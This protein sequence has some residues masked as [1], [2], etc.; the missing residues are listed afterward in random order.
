MVYKVIGLMS[1][2]SLDGLDL[3]FAHFNEQAGA[4]TFEI[5]ETACYDYPPAW[6]EQLSSATGLSAR[7][8]C[9]LH[10]AYGH[11]LGEMSNRFIEEKKIQLEAD[12]IASHGHTVFHEPALGMTAQLGDGAAIASETG[13]AVVSDLRA[14]DVA[15]GGEGAPI[16]PVGEKLLFPEHNL[17]LNLGGIANVSFHRNGHVIAFDVCPANRVLNELAVLLGKPFDENGTLAS[18]GVLNKQLLEQLN[19]LEYYDRPWPKSL[20]NSFGTDTVLPLLGKQ[21][22]SIQGKLRT[23]VEH[24]AIQVS[25]SIKNLINEGRNTQEHKLL[26]TGGGAFNSFL[27][28]ILAEKLAPLGVAVLIPAPEVVK[29]KE[30][31]IMAFLGVLRWRENNSTL[32]SVTGARRNSTGGA[33]WMG[34]EG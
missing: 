23:Y 16:V 32:S 18:G 19:A 33:L 25:L 7:A 1:G 31:L 9:L 27:T 30:A 26:V 24:I 22:L 34:Q 28:D 12:L 13:M 20:A 3:V 6:K 17:F 8:Y 11:Y 2:S 29:F 10:G 4:W 5:K 14:L 15:L 21:S